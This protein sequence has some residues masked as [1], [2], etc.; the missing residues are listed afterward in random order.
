MVFHTV[1][2]CCTGIYVSL[3]EEDACETTRKGGD[4]HLVLRTLRPEQLSAVG[5][6]ITDLSGKGQ[7]VLSTLADPHPQGCIYKP[8]GDVPTYTCFPENTRGF[9]YYHKPPDGPEFSAGVRFRICNSAA[10]FEHGRDLLD[11]RG[12][13]WS[14]KLLELVKHNQHRQFL[15]LLRAENLIDEELIHDINKLDTTHNV[16]RCHASLSDPFYMNLGHTSK[17]ITYVTRAKLVR[18]MFA[19]KAFRVHTATN[20]YVSP[21]TGLIKARFELSDLPEHKTLGPTLVIRVLKVVEPVNLLFQTTKI[22]IPVPGTLLY[23]N[24]HGRR[25]R[26]V[27]VPLKKQPM[28]DDLLELARAAWA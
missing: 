11:T 22:P 14:P 13:I 15:S 25:R 1:C 4:R 6:E 27:H 9:F 18:L 7:L 19:Q 26:V 17:K 21:L 16:R 2:T 3:R 12:D 24:V 8:R 20:S 28:A 5:Q 10:D 23:R